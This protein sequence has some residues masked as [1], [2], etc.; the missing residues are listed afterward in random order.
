MWRLPGGS[1]KPGVASEHAESLPTEAACGDLQRHSDCTG[2]LEDLKMKLLFTWLKFAGQTGEGRAAQ[3]Q[4]EKR[5]ADRDSQLQSHK[6]SP[7]TSA[8]NWPAHSNRNN[9][10]NG[11]KMMQNAEGK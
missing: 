7:C 11:R 3:R 2:N 8:E 9:T 6:G 10:Q 1:G 4:W 5:T